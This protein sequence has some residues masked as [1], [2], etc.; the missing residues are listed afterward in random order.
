MTNADKIRSMTDESLAFLFANFEDWTEESDKT[1]EETIEDWLEWLK[2]EV[3][4]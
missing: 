1:E 4:E 2:Q 3:E